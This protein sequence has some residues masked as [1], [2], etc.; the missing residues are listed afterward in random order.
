MSF[1]ALE[2]TPM[3]YSIWTLLAEPEYA[4]KIVL[5]DY[6]LS[7]SDAVASEA[8]SMEFAPV[9]NYTRIIELRGERNRLRFLASRVA[10]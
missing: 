10:A 9:L 5:R 8:R 1:V 4:Q 7:M 3:N 2:E 6:L